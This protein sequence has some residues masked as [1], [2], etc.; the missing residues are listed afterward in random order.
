MLPA[1]AWMKP[2]RM[3]RKVLLP[4]PLGPITVMNS[5]S[6]ALNSP[7]SRIGRE[8]LFFEYDLRIPE[9]CRAILSGGAA[10][11]TGGLWRGFGGSRYSGL[12]P[13]VLTTEEAAGL[14]S[15]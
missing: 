4:Q 8:R 11:L 5:P 7:R 15:M 6:R 1:S 14:V 2:P 13:L 12:V 9:A 3:W 10:V